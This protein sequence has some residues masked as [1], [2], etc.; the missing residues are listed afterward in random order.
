MHAA[1]EQLRQLLARVR[2][3][4]RRVLKLFTGTADYWLEYMEEFLVIFPA[5]SVRRSLAV[6]SSGVPF[7]Q[8]PA[9]Q[10][11]LQ[12][13]Y[14]TVDEYSQT[15]AR[16]PM[17]SHLAANILMAAVHGMI[18]FPCMSRSMEWTDTRLMVKHLVAG[19]VSE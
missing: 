1:T 17:P 4:A 14:R 13:Y 19:M 11:S 2:S 16:P 9:A 8:S 18:V 5:P 12:L 10:D 15:L 3:P 7:G 6:S